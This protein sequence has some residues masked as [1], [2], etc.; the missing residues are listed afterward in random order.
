MKTFECKFR[1]GPVVLVSREIAFTFP[2]SY[3]YLA[4][5]LR[6]MGEEVHIV[7]RNS[8][9]KT[10]VKQIMDLNPVLVGF[11]SLYPELQEIGDI[12]TSLDK[13]GRKFPVVIGGQ[14]VSPIPEFAVSVTGT[15]FGIVGEGE[16]I[17]HQ[18]VTA[19]REGKDVYGVNGVVIRHGNET[20]STSP[21]K[22]IKDLSKLPAIPYDLFP[23]D[24]WLPI[25]RWYAANCPQPHW[26]FEDR[27]INV[28]G[29]R[30]CPFRCNFCYHHSKPR[31]RSIPKMI[32]EGAEALD[33]FNG[34]MLYFS[35]DLVLASPK[36]AQELVGAIGS[37]KKPIEYS[38]SARFD[39]L[40]QMD[41]ELL[42]A[43]K[44]TGC[45]IMGLGIESGSNRI[46][47]IVGKNCTSEMILNGLER[48][49]KVGIL[50]TVSI[51]VGQYTETKEDVEDSIELMRKSVRSNPNIQYAFTITTPFPGS[52]LYK[53]I[54]QK[55]YLRNH[56]DFY[57]IYFSTSKEWQQ[58]VNLSAMSAEEVVKMYRKINKVY[59]QEKFNALGLKVPMIGNLQIALGKTA[60]VINNKILCK[61]SNDDASSRIP[62][63]Y[64]FFRDSTL[65][66]L[67]RCRLRL[68]GFQ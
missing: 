7:F 60:A 27:V 43:M 14:M 61:L 2:L 55:G 24:Q 53:L 52:Q 46:L 12:I 13:V 54:F 48:L 22:Y 36:R 23:Q 1:Q 34:N 8:D 41:D 40:A 31:Y 64:H 29:G 3:A 33:R 26:R 35:D 42:Y 47:R 66:K 17:L 58:V 30:G 20:I 62:K 10:L 57:N 25:G 51:M 39:I 21:G 44:A 45:R 16:I 19:L 15:D 67:D 28:H 9:R 18:L 56:K 32:A 6:E 11:G 50:P 4:G 49:K 63:A 5:Y 37:L 65:H 38:V 59:L 68:E